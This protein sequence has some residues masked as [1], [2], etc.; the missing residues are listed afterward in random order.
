MTYAVTTHFRVRVAER[1]GATVNADILARALSVAIDDPADARAAFLRKVQ[2]NG[3]RLFQFYLGEYGVFYALVNSNARTFVTV[4]KP[5]HSCGVANQDV[6][7]L[8]GLDG[9]F[10]EVL[11]P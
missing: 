10:C 3:L 8:P 11:F 6:Y 2:K 5:G 9:L 4:L 1:I 7:I